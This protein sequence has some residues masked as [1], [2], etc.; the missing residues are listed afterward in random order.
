MSESDDFD[1]DLD[2]DSDDESW[3]DGLRFLLTKG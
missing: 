1:E 2:E 3:E